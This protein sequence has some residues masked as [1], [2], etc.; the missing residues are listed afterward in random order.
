MNRFG[1][2]VRD[3]LSCGEARRFNPAMCVDLLTDGIGFPLLGERVRVRGKE[4]ET[5]PNAQKNCADSILPIGAQ[6]LFA[7]VLRCSTPLSPHPGYDFW[8]TAGFCS[9]ALVSYFWSSDSI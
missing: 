9:L 4:M 2:R 5:D 1:R 8:E 6:R 3:R 7:G